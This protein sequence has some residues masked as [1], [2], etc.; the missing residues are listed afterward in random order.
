MS[1]VT[2][3]P[4][5]LYQRLARLVVKV[6]PVQ[7]PT[8]Q[9][10]AGGGAV[11]HRPILRELLTLPQHRHALRGVES[12]DVGLRL[13]PAGSVAVRFPLDVGERL[14]AELGDESA[15]VVRLDVLER[16]YWKDVAR[17]RVPV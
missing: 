9:S 15:V 4:V 8:E 7:R 17:R 12:D 1:Q 16:R 2:E 13:R 3:A 10:A 14:C 6:L 5:E 11:R